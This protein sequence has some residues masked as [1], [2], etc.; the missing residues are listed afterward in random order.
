M[1]QGLNYIMV[2]T[3]QQLC[4]I[5]IVLEIKLE[6]HWNSAEKGN[7]KPSQSD[8]NAHKTLKR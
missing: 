7:Q 1:D 3:W 8:I 4:C 5:F 2:Y 6:E